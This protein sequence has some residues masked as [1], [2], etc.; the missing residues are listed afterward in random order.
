MGL[1]T[2]LFNTLLSGS[3]M[4]AKKTIKVK[5]LELREGKRR[6]L[7]EEYENYQ[8]YLRGDKSGKLYSATRQQAERLLMR[9]R[10]QNGG[11]VDP[12]KTIHW[13]CGTTSTT[14]IRRIQS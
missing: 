14:F 10:G 1:N 2:A 6:L 9:L 8:R 12:Q 5:I 3:L 4:L 13:Y 7:E 11:K